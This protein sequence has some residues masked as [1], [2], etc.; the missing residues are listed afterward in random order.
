MNPLDSFSAAPRRR[1]PRILVVT[2]EITYLPEGMGNMANAMRAKAGGLADVSASLVAALFDLGADVHVALPHYRRMFHI[3][4]G[5]LISEELRKYKNKLP[6]ARIH[7]AED[8]MFYYRDQVYNPYS[9]DDWR[10]ALAFQREVIN[11]IVPRVAP[12]LIH[13][14]DWMTGLVPAM[15]RRLN[16]PCLFTL[17]NIHTYEV[18]LERIEESGI[19]AA[20]F[21]NHLYY[22]WPPGNYEWA[23]ANDPVDLQSSGLF[24]SHFINTVSPTFLKEIVDG[25]HSMIP[26]NVRYEVGQKWHNG[27]AAGILNAPD[28][29]YNPRTDPALACLYSAADHAAGKRA[30]K[31]QLQE[32]L[33]LV[34]DPNA[35]VFFWPSRLD[36]IQ[37]GPQLL[38]QILYDVVA[39]YAARNLQVV[40]VANGAY[41]VHFHN[42]VRHHGLERRVAVCDFDESLSRLAYAASDFMLMPSS[43][44]PC[45]LPQMTSCIYG[46]LPVVHDTGGLHDT[47]THLNLAASTGNGFV[48]RDFDRG[49]LRWA[50]EQALAF[51]A[52]SPAVRAAT[53]GRVMTE[54]VSTFNHDVTARQYFDIYEAML[55]RPLINAY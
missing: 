30:N 25:R 22:K 21:W 43:F 35:P 33:G 24:A 50:M 8:R 10:V 28:P 18:T 19:D 16:I 12:D 38:T 47:V 15:A 48:F 11:N 27:C 44:E 36:P 45:G 26:G 2:P 41:Q 17:H 6:D 55:N 37:K 54:S 5:H 1:N 20:E 40:I 4:V 13:C 49:G 46:S 53:I 51:H 7:L 23:R 3:D 39:A 9:S 42:I 31:Q 29:S 14:N 52:M 32:R 34:E